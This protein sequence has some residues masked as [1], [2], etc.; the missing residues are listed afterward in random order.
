MT[1]NLHPVAE[2]RGVTKRYGPVLAL[3]DVDLAV[4]PGEVMALL[5]PNGAG[6]TTAV[7]LLLGLLRPNGGSVSLFGRRPDAIEAKVRVGAMLQIPGVPATLTVREHL[8]SFA[9]YYPASLPLHQVMEMAGL[10]EVGNRQYGNLS[11]GQ[12]QR[13]HFALAIVGNPDLL[14]LD[15]PT[16]GLDVASR[17][18][19]WQQV[20][21]FIRGGRTVVLTT[22]YLE[23]ADALADRV[24][25]IDR[26]RVLAVGTPA[27]IKAQTAGQRIKA[28]TALT[29]A[30]IAAIAQV[31]KVERVGAAVEILTADA[32]GVVREL[33]ARDG[34]LGGLEVTG[35]GLEEAFLALTNEGPPRSDAA[36][37]K[38]LVSPDPAGMASTSYASR[39]GGHA[40]NETGVKR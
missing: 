21:D 39:I 4:R 30:E 24:V 15:E 23:E 3:D 19:F 36:G 33:L 34:G 5:G 8:A 14:F 25:V 11:G 1:N 7:S 38:A 2:L 16:T 35:A 17:R 28:V 40:A 26:G 13:L 10:G 9:S 6:K 18:A 32:A 27:A 20:R 31:A 12:R 22:H 29:T 37:A